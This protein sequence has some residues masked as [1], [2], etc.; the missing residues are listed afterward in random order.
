MQAILG[1]ARQLVETFEEI[2][3]EQATVLLE[4]AIQ[5]K[6]ATAR[7]KNKVDEGDKM[8]RGVMPGLWCGKHFGRGANMWVA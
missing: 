2:N 7:R 5:T 3:Y 8:K 6:R 4:T 1:V